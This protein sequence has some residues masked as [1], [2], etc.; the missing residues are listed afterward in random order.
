MEISTVP[1]NRGAL[2]D[3]AMAARMLNLPRKTLR[4]WRCLG[5]GPEFVKLGRAVRYRTGA[6]EAFAGGPLD[7][8]TPTPA[9]AEKAGAAGDVE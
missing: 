1:T 7:I 6:L 9:T 8:P 5:R 3:E 2:V 4:A